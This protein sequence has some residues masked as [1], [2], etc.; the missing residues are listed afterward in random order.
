MTIHELLQR[1]QTRLIHAQSDEPQANSEWLL[2]H[3][4]HV[5]RTWVLANSGFD[6]SE[7]DAR[8]FEQLLV[9]KETGEPLSHI[10]GF[11]PFCGLD[12]VVTPDVLTPRP[13]T[14]DLVERVSTYFDK[15]G[16][17]LFLDMCTGSGCIAAALAHKFPRASILAVDISQAA[18]QV[19]Q[20]N[21]RKHKLQD[22][23]QLLQSN[24]WEE[25]AGTFDLIIANPPYIPTENLNTLTREVQHEPRLALDGGA[26]GY[27]VTRPLCQAAD[28]FLRPGG[29]LALEL[30]DGQAWPL[31][32]GLA[33]I[34]WKADVKKDI[35]NIERFV[36]ATR[37]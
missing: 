28:S 27:E 14:E 25:V 33:E 12:I 37:D 10:V 23:V 17:H 11:Q 29:L 35:F 32:R 22:R 31:A 21:I 13:E 26:D 3:V 15:R 18:L 30:D 36:F 7:K 4:L 20:E 6:V 24:L 2:A 34:G 9:R 1:A 16:E 5:T 8:T 19:A